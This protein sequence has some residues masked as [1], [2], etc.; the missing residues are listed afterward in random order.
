MWYGGE[1]KNKQNII[2]L[3]FFEEP[4]VADKTLLGKTLLYIIFLQ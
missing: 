1:E 4:L 3:F 2:V